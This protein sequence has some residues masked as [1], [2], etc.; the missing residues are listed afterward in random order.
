MIKKITWMIPVLLLML[1][2]AGCRQP[3]PS[4]APVT[5]EP[6]AAPTAQPATATPVPTKAP[7]EFLILGSDWNAG[8][9]QAAELGEEQV[10]NHY[11]TNY[12][13]YDEV[14]IDDELLLVERV[15]DEKREEIG[16]MFEMISEPGELPQRYKSWAIDIQPRCYIAYTVKNV[17]GDTIGVNFSSHCPLC[18]H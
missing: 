5:E 12:V 13:Q 16:R 10:F 8:Y 11:V 2:L 15:C 6:T 1:L 18:N 9:S 17:S 3:T 4:A 14:I 7:P